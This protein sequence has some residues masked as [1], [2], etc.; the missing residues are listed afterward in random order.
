MVQRNGIPTP[1]YAGADGCPFCA[2][3]RWV[4]VVALVRFG[5]FT[6]F[7]LMR[8]NP[9]DTDPNTATISFLHAKYH[10]AYS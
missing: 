8:S 9:P 7:T 1:F 3:E 6:G 4:L 2:A 10:R 5:S